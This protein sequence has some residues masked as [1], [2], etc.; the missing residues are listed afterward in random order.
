MLA[1]NRSQAA[2]S[3]QLA[4]PAAAASSRGLPEAAGCYWLPAHVYACEMSSAVILLDLKKDRYFGL[5][6]KESSWL[7]SVVRNWPNATPGSAASSSASH[8]FCVSAAADLLRSE[9]LTRDEPNCRFSNASAIDLDGEL[10]SIGD[11]LHSRPPVCTMDVLNLLRAYGHARAALRWRSFYDVV[12]D[13]WR[14]KQRAANPM[15]EEHLERVIDLVCVFRR[16]RPIVFNAKDMCLIHALTL[17]TFLSYYGVYPAWVIGVQMQPWCAH[18]WVQYRNL[19]FDTNPEK[20]CEY[21]PI[22]VV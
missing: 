20:V 15:P 16:L 3:D 11:E 14:R 12:H 17:T 8:E 21:T 13:V 7:S 9:L 18:S 6:R 10:I 1:A 19:L 5:D 4:M 22:L 2:D